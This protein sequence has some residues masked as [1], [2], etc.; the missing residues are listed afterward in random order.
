MVSQSVCV[1]TYINSRCAAYSLD[2]K[3]IWSSANLFAN[4]RA[5]SH[6]NRSLLILN[7]HTHTYTASAAVFKHTLTIFCFAFTYSSIH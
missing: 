5:L 7:T 1:C 4:I 3:G 6:C 2:M